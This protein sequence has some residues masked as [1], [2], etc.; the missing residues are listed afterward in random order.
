MQTESIAIP[1]TATALHQRQYE[2]MHV[3][4][5]QQQQPVHNDD[6]D[7]DNADKKRRR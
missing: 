7:D 6:H 5:Q 1:R 3:Q 4:Q 2:L